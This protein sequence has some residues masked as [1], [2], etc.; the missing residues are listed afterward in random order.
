VRC[1]VCE[2]V[3]P[4]QESRTAGASSGVYPDMVDSMS[5]WE[6]QEPS[7][8]RSLCINGLNLC[9]RIQTLG[10]RN[11]GGH[12]GGWAGVVARMKGNG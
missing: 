5:V 9:N 11:D 6:V 2:R 12:C 10:T 1:R 8:N 3:L 4:E 7:S